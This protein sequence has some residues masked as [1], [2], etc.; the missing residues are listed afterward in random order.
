MK[1]KLR[2]LIFILVLGSVSSLALTGIQGYSTPK[3]ERYRQMKLK[4]T[5]LDAAG[6][7]YSHENFDEVFLK[8][9]KEIKKENL[10]YYLSP[11]NMYIFEFKGRGLWGMIEGVVTLNSDLETIE[12]IRIISQEET[13]G[14][15]GRISEEGFL[16]KFKKKKISPKLFLA[17]RRKATGDNEID[18]ISGATMTSGALLDIIN[19]SVMNFRDI[20]ED[21][22]ENR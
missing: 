6:I 18:A 8:N 11:R 19:E 16:S 1:G 22:N 7:E 2:D 5:I 17:L 3:I 9:I 10:V 4:M 15:G 14:L 20:I 13:P 12:S 21:Q